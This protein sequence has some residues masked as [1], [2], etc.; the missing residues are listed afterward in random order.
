MLPLPPVVLVCNQAKEDW[1]GLETLSWFLPFIYPSISVCVCLN[2]EVWRPPLLGLQVGYPGHVLW[3]DSYIWCRGG[4]KAS[5]IGTR[6]EMLDRLTQMINSKILFR[7]LYLSF[8]YMN[9]G[10]KNGLYKV[11]F[12]ARSQLILIALRLFY[13]Q[14]IRIVQRVYKLINSGGLAK[15]NYF[16]ELWLYG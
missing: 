3:Q 14:Y 12:G 5:Q 2:R 6:H 9:L 15:K 8:C 16:V 11:R 1:G 7:L 10:V 13:G 4:K